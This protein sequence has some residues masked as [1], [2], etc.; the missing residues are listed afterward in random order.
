MMMTARKTFFTLMT[1]MIPMRRKTIIPIKPNLNW[2]R[3]RMRNPNRSLHLDDREGHALNKASVPA[4]Q[5][6]ETNPIRAMVA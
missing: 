5:A 1:M 2:K 4:P 3:M 6:V